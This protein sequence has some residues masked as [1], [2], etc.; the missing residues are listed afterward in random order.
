MPASKVVTG[1]FNS[2]YRGKPFGNAQGWL[3]NLNEKHCN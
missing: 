3:E 2:T 1:Y